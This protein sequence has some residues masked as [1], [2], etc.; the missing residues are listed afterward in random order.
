VGFTDKDCSFRSVWQRLFSR[1]FYRA[2]ATPFR[3]HGVHK[4]A[5]SRTI[6]NRKKK[7]KRKLSLNT[8]QNDKGGG[9]HV[10]MGNYQR[11]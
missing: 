4:M 2:G 1:T 6:L 9:S 10:E 11:K 7:E 3:Y 5:A 8:Q